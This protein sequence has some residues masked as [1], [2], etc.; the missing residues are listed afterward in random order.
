MSDGFESWKNK[1][2]LPKCFGIVFIYFITLS[3]LFPRKDHTGYDASL[4]N[5]VRKTVDQSE[6]LRAKCDFLTL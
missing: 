3:W 4:T 1:H 6:T 5:R 2:V